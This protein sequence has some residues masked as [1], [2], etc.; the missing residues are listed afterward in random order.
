MDPASLPALPCLLS[1]PR[2]TP[3]LAACAGDQG[4]AVRLYTWN[5]A[6]A[7]AFWGPVHALEVVLRNAEHTQLVTRFG[8][9]DWWSNPR[10]QLHK[11]MADQLQQAIVAAGKTAGRQSRVMIADDVVA[12]L[13]FGFWSGL[14][15]KGQG[16]AQYETQFWQPA[17]SKAFPGYTGRRA[18]LHSQLESLRLFRNR[19]AHHEPIFGRHLAA[20]HATILRVAGYLAPDADAYIAG[21]SR[22]PAVLTARPAAV[23]SGQGSAF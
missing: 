6:A 13:S 8:Q 19:I 23:T 17:L 10:V 3:Y 12:N 5:I 14:V 7:S 22:V 11:S 16:G 21:H 2:L 18:P 4:Q 20:D 1:Q 9:D 15:G